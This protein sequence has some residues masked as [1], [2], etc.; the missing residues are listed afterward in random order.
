MK[1]ELYIVVTGEDGESGTGGF[2][3]LVTAD[4]KKAVR[5]LRKVVS[6]LGYEHLE[7]GTNDGDDRAEERYDSD[8]MHAHV[9]TYGSGLSFEATVKVVSEDEFEKE[10]C[11]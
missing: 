6:S 7:R 4:R 3:H 2:I 8:G 1:K 11:I 9:Y 10:T 5:T